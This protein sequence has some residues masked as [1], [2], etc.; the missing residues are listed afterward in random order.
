MPLVALLAAAPRTGRGQLRDALGSW[1][2][3]SL[4]YS[5]TPRLSLFVEAQVRSLGFYRQFHYHEYKGG[6]DFR[7]HPAARLALG[8]GKYDTYREGGNFRR[9]KNSD[10]VR[11]WPQLLLTQNVGPFKMEHRYR[12][13]LR[14]LTT[15][16]RNRF[17]YRLGV[18]YTL[19]ANGQGRAPWQLSASNELFLTDRGPYFERNRLLLAATWDAPGPAALQLGYLRQLDYRINDETGRDF[20]LV[21][22]FWELK[23][24]AAAPAAAPDGAGGRD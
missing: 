14:F 17:R 24:D 12:A 19:P 20:L 22:L 23:R 9:P 1:N 11:L 10:E 2:I 4:R 5:H 21:G 18:A 15:G 6:L 16:Y 3:L 7:V 13:E 8:V